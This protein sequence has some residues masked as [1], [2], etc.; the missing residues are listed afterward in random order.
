MF[1][2]PVIDEKNEDIK[3]LAQK[4]KK[5]DYDGYISLEIIRGENMPEEELIE[6][7]QRLNKQIAEA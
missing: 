1:H 6:T 7:A 3:D 5:I 4:M 2:N